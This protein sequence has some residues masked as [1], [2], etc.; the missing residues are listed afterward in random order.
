MS[1]VKLESME[2]IIVSIVTWNGR[3]FFNTSS[4]A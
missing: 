4:L 3:K 2:N 1:E